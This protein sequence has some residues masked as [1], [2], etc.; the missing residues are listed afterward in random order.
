MKEPLLDNESISAFVASSIHLTL[1]PFLRY[2]S[3]KYLS[4]FSNV[5]FGFAIKSSFLSFRS[6]NFFFKLGFPSES[7]S[8]SLKS[9]SSIEYC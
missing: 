9:I 4:K 5:D 6:L 8:N 2:W 3:I 1:P 7:T